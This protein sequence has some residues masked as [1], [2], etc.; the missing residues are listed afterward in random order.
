MKDLK[1]NFQGKQAIV[2]GS[3]N[4]A[5]YA[6]EKLHELGAKA[7]TCSDS[8]GFIYD[9]EGIDLALLKEIK[10]VKQER[11]TAYANARPSAE[12]HEGASVW[13]FDVQ[14]ELAFPC[15]TQNEINLE[16]AKRAKANGVGLFLKVP[17][18]Q[19]L[20]KRQNILLRKES[21]IVLGKRLMRVA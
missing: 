10:E 7:I 11:L 12:Y 17:I 18:C 1:E 19:A 6:I 2:S 15:A 20:L 13:D 14:A 16:Q 3:G 21:T 8:S 9:K 4:V 5:I